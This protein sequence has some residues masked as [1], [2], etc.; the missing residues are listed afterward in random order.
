[1]T[2]KRREEDKGV[3]QRYRCYWCGH[4]LAPAETACPQCGEEFDGVIR[5]DIPDLCECQRCV[6]A[7]RGADDA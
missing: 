5:P 7:R 1:M 6:V 2:R 3:W 4:R